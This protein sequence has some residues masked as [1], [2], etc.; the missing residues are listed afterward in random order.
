M[1][2][3]FETCALSETNIE[4][5]G[6]PVCGPAHIE[7][8][9]RPVCGPAHIEDQGRPVCGPAHRSAAVVSQVGYWID[10]LRDRASFSIAVGSLAAHSLVEKVDI[11]TPIDPQATLDLVAAVVAK[12]GRLRVLTLH[13][14]VPF[15]APLLEA[16]EAFEATKAR[17][18]IDGI[19][20][21]RHAGD[22]GRWLQHLDCVDVVHLTVMDPHALE[23]F[24][25]AVLSSKCSKRI[26]TLEIDDFGGFYEQSFID[27]F[28]KHDIRVDSIVI[29]SNLVYLENVDFSVMK[30]SRV[31]LRMRN[32]CWLDPSKKIKLLNLLTDIDIDDSPPDTLQFIIEHVDDMA[33]LKRIHVHRYFRRDVVLLHFD[34]LS[35]FLD[36]ISRRGIIIS[37]GG[38]LITDPRAASVCHLVARAGIA[39]D[40]EVSGG[41]EA[42]NLCR[43]LLMYEMGR[44]RTPPHGLD[45]YPGVKQMW[46]VT[47][48]D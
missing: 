1:K 41:G 25:Q 39:W 47:Q 42:W 16:F 14:V 3:M 43:S 12:H 9:G 20:L 21:S 22:S 28:T 44:S 18:R 6:R 4:D 30:S 38:D 35:T 15:H 48:S 46:P 24:P 29:N 10:D 34:L 7:D 13:S 37:F 5:Q 45:A 26:E 11:V 33:A 23:R 40:L 19:C 17:P 36:V 2:L 31:T 32:T 27:Y 8:Q